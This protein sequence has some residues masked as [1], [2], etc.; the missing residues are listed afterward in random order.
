MVPQKERAPRR[1]RQKTGQLR[2]AGNTPSGPLAAA[3]AISGAAPAHEL[4]E[5]AELEAENRRLKQ[6]LAAKLQ[7]ENVWLREQ[8]QRAR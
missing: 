1:S 4:D 7:K 8:L 2:K 5:L 3:D 6:M